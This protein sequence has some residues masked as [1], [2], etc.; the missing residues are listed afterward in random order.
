M[1]LLDTHI[2]HW[3]VNQI[4]DKLPPNLRILIEEAAEVGVSSISCFEMACLVKHERICLPMSFN[5]WLSQ[6]EEAAIIRFL[7]VTPIIAAN[8][9]A[10]PEHHRDPMDR[11]IISTALYYDAQLL[12][13]DTTFPLYRDVGLRLISSN[14]GI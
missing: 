12:S 13:F 8:A 2:W 14:S 1:I 9:V 11:L 10:L 5:E 6:V 4:P 7:P 3:W